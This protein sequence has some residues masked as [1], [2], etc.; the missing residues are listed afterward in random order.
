MTH[1]FLGGL[2]EGHP[3]ESLESSEIAG[4]TLPPGNLGREGLAKARGRAIDLWT[5]ARQV[6]YDPEGH[7]QF[8]GTVQVGNH[9]IEGSITADA[10]TCRV[11][12][13]TPS[14]LKGKQRLRA[15]VQM[16]FV[17][18]LDPVRPWHGLLIGRHF[19][20]DRLWSV[21]IGPLGK[22]PE[23][24]KQQADRMLA[25]LVDLYVEGLVAP[26]PL[27]GETAFIWQRNI[28]NGRDVAIKKAREAW[29]T[30]R[31]SPEMKDPA[32]AFL[33]PELVSMAALAHSSFPS[34]AERLWGP[35]IPL[36][37]EKGL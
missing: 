29:E 31:F 16:L 34:Y 25:G 3:I 22:D 33:F 14:R 15:F 32:N 35:I 24:R 37:V 11:D 4:D 13:V 17:T 23:R 1:R 12:M 6:G 28:R 7:E 19:R 30:D 18:A 36:L 27:P 9:V 5:A 20:G 8:T 26:I 21:K 2:L 10:A